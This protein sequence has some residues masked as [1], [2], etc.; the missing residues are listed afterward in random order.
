MDSIT[1]LELEKRIEEFKA[2]KNREVKAKSIFT[3]KKID[4]SVAYDF[5]REHHYLGDAK[6]FS[7]HAYGLYHIESNQLMGVTTF[8]NP[9]GITTLKGWFG[10]TN[11]DQSVLELS[12]LCVLP[13]LNGTNATSFLLGNSLKLLKRENIRAVITLADDSRHIGS[14]YQVCNFDYYGLTNKKTDFYSYDDGGKLNPRGSTKD[15]QGVW[16][17]RTRK[18]R[19]AYILDKTLKCKYTK[20][21]QY[22][23]KGETSEYGCCGGTKVVTDKRFDVDYTCPRCTGELKQIPREE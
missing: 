18:H 12:R 17:H 5:I 19:Y 2:F 15:K 13:H 1:I 9:Q 4:K 8:S 20:L 14:I 21:D 11:E 23:N 6:F 3:L 16:L 7:K 10:L 22:P